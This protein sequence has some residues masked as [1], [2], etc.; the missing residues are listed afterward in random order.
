[1]TD[2][3]F[4]ELVGSPETVGNGSGV[5]LRLTSFGTEEPDVG[6]GALRFSG[7]AEG[8]AYEHAVGEQLAYLPRLRSFATDTYGEILTTYIGWA[9]GYL[10]ALVGESYEEVGLLPSAGYGDGALL[11]LTGVATGSVNLVGTA[12]GTLRLRSYGLEDSGDWGISSLPAFASEALEDAPVAENFFSLQQHPGVLLA[13]AG[14]VF[15]STYG[16]V[17]EVAAPLEAIQTSSI[18]E[19]LVVTDAM[20]A[21]RIYYAAIEDTVTIT[22]AMRLAYEVLVEEE[23]TLTAD[24]LPSVRAMVRTLDTLLLTAAVSSQLQAEVAMAAVITVGAS[25]KPG[26]AATMLADIEIA[27]AVQQTMHAVA[28]AFEQV[29]VTGEYIGSLR[30]FVD[31]A[32]SASV[33]TGFSNN[34]ALNVMLEE[35]VSVNAIFSLYGQAFSVWIMSPDNEAVYQYENFNFNSFAGLGGA[36][37]GA[38]DH[39][40]YLLEGDDDAGE[41]IDARV[42]TGLLDFGTGRLKQLSRAYLGYT[43]TGSLLLKTVTIAS[44]GAERGKKV[45]DWYELTRVHDDMAEGRIPVGTGLKSVYWQFVLHNKAGA[46]FVT[47]EIKLYPLVADRRIK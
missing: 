9:W 46:D 33:E 37:F 4:E 13:F 34:A 1:M 30:F 3:V 10:P 18:H 32:E 21:A 5:L 40:V 24:H 26:W 25:F 22:A 16:E 17:I 2:I 6:F 8:T 41:D 28:T 29:T 31:V 38:N 23:V 36:Y 43:S 20:I 19:R 47:D 14:N 27:D 7:A 35:G 15:F 39:G 11:T 45:E 42:R 12:A 44:E